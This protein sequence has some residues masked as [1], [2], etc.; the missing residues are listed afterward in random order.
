[1]PRKVAAI[2]FSPNL[3]SVQA[4]IAPLMI[5]FTTAPDEERFLEQGAVPFT[6]RS[7]GD[8][9]PLTNSER[10]VR[11]EI[12]VYRAQAGDVIDTI[13]AK[14]GLQPT[15]I[16]YSNPEILQYPDALAIDQEVRIPPVDGAIHTVVAGDT[17]DSI[18]E[19]YQVS[20]ETIAQFASNKLSAPYTLSIG[21]ELVIP[22]GIAP[23]PPEPEPE[24]EPYSSAEYTRNVTEEHT[25][26]GSLDWPVNGLITQD[27]YDYHIA[28]DIY[29]VI[30]TPVYAAD[31]GYVYKMEQLDWS[32][33][34]YMLIDHGNGIVTRYAHL[35][36][37]DVSVGESV[38]KGQ[39]IGRIGS[40]GKSTGPHL[41]FEVIVNGQQVCPWGYLP[42]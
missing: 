32:Y 11:T 16:I 5:R 18:A 29:N 39:L 25:A 2:S 33:G 42:D 35:S 13:A 37:F 38:Q 34:W 28:L 23:A 20:V 4:D 7:V 12:L 24:P 6:S 26:T 36:E 8:V 30:G 1:M 19:T 9:V 40:T 41:H 3:T 21:Q 14:F 31:S 10:S 27:C 22:G 17:I 15:T